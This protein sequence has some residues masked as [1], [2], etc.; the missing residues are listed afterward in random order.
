MPLPQLP[1]KHQH[2]GLLTGA[3]MVAYRRLLGRFPKGEAPESVLICLETSLPRRMRRAFPFRPIGRLGGDLFRLRRG[4]GKV[5]VA[6]NLGV[7]APAVVG[8]AEELLGWG[9]RNFALL[10]WAGGLQPDLADGT[11]VIVDQAIR[12]DGV[13]HH[14]L[15]DAGRVASHPGL[16]NRLAQ[17]LK[18]SGS[19]YHLGCTWSTAAPYRETGPEV[20]HYRGEGVLTVEMEA[21]G[22]FAFGQAHA[23]N[24]MAGVVV[25]DSLS[26]LGWQPPQELLAIER[27]LER[28]YSAMLDTLQDV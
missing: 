17:V 9:T 14:Y 6:I 8:L 22:L 15:P 24:T 27:S 20:A 18:H 25:G 16:T 3:K 13:S 12:D 23:V 2:A 5:A 26:D 7:G 21:A 10:S 4:G 11:I 19:T 28:L 1:D